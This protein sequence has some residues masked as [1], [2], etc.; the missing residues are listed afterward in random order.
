MIEEKLNRCGRSL[1]TYDEMYRTSLQF[2]QEPHKIWAYGRFEDK[3][4][5]LKLT[6][7]DRLTYVRNAGY[8]TP[9]LSLPFKLL[10]DNSGQKMLMVPRGGIEPP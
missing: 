9:D 7:T 3:R 2:L 4:A 8:R 1:K 10:G 6:F 5:V